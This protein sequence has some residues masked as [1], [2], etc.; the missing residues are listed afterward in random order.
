MESDFAAPEPNAPFRPEVP[1][2]FSC[3]I[4]AKTTLLRKNTWMNP[5][6]LLLNTHGGSTIKNPKKFIRTNQ[7]P[8][9]ILLFQFSGGVINL[10][11][12]APGSA[13][14]IVP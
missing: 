7:F 1:L 14:E 5:P 2:K 8:P 3:T 12:G 11:F 13:T 10:G 6:L 9:T 4:L